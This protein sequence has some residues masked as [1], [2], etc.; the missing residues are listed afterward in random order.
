VDNKE[1][2]AKGMKSKSE[3]EMKAKERRRE[4]GVIYKEKEDK[5]EHGWYMI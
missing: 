1:K 3:R 4:E 5:S 2:K